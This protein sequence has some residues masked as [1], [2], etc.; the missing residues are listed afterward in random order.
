MTLTCAPVVP[1]ICTVPN[2]STHPIGDG[3][4]AEEMDQTL[5]SLRPEK[6]TQFSEEYYTS[7]AYVMIVI[8]IGGSTVAVPEDR[9]ISLLLSC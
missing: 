3:V 1:S 2:C 4:K 5:Y 6:K 8:I 7:Y 9:W